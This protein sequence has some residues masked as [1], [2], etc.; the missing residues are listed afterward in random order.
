MKFKIN[1]TFLYGL[2]VQAYACGSAC[3]FNTLNAFNKSI[4]NI[5]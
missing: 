2:H 1:A 5:L 3:I 4:K